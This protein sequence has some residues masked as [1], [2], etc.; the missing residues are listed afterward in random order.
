MLSFDYRAFRKA[1]VERVERESNGS[2]T[3]L[4]SWRLRE[5]NNIL[6]SH[7]SW[8]ACPC[9]RDISSFEPNNTD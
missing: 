7:P 1:W 8:R 9:P 2:L 4:Y 5:W 6:F 3:M